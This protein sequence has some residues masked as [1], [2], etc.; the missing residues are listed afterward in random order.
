M[1]KINEMNEMDKTLKRCELLRPCGKL[2]FDKLSKQNIGNL[3]LSVTGSNGKLPQKISMEILN[4]YCDWCKSSFGWGSV[5]SKDFLLGYMEYANKVFTYES[6]DMMMKKLVL[7][8]VVTN[9]Q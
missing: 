8:S 3:L 7:L 5:I 2:N 1:S 9:L 6:K 4:K